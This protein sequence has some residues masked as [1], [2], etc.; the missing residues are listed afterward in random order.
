MSRFTGR[1]ADSCVPQ[2]II[3]CVNNTTFDRPSVDSSPGMSTALW[4]MK[5]VDA[6]D[7]SF[8]IILAADGAVM[9]GMHRVARALLQGRHEIVGVQFDADP[10]PDHV[11]RGPNE[12]P[13]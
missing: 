5:L 7:L 6:A 3:T 10:K 4:N 12:L 9:D 2:R 13:Y 8:P 1:D 11:G